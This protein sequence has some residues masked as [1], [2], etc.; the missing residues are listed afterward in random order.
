MTI[1]NGLKVSQPMECSY[2][3]DGFTGKR[4]TPFT[5][6]VFQ[7]KAI[8]RHL[9]DVGVNFIWTIP[10]CSIRITDDEL[11][12]SKEGF[13]VMPVALQLLD[14]NTSEPFGFIDFYDENAA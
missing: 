11:A 2:N 1:S 13:A 8:L 12:F 9:P 14:D 7:G 3:Y 4:M 5:Q 10:K 6:T